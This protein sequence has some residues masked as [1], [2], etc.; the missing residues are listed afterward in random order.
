MLKRFYVPK[1]NGKM[2]PIG[3]PSYDSRAISRAF[4]D[5]IYYV[6]IDKFLPMQHG[7]RVKR[8]THTALFEV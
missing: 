5:M 4:N 3:A 2:R 7:F 1:P 8:G 6:F